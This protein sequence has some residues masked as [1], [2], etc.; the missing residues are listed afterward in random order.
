M[1]HRLA[2]ALLLLLLATC[3]TKNDTTNYL[4]AIL[5][6][7]GTPTPSSPAPSSCPTATM[8]A[9][10]VFDG[11]PTTIRVGEATQLDATPYAGPVKLTVEC[12][13]AK[14]IA[15]F[16]DS[17]VCV[18]AGEVGSYTP[19]VRGLSPGTCVFR[20]AVDNVTSPPVAITV[21]P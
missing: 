17:S 12:S 10:K 14:P 9:L 4:S 11:Q 6:P 18:R 20:A 16:G 21:L 3:V 19:E 1:L 8:V 15:W 2:G 5:T 7:S 13:L